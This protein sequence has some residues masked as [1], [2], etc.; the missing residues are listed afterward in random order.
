MN[1]KF[2][3]LILKPV[4]TEKSTLASEFK[5]YIFLVHRNAN[6]YS[7]SKAIESIFNVD[8]IK[9]NIINTIG[10]TK[11]FKGTLGKQSDRKKAIISVAKDHVIEFGVGGVK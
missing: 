10:K 8:V 2:Y 5:K 7:I 4:V 11:R 1:Y 6:K 9:V 3:D